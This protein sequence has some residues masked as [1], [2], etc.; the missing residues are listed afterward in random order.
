[1]RYDIFTGKTSLVKFKSFVL[2]MSFVGNTINFLQ[3]KWSLRYVWVLVLNKVCTTIFH[4]FLFCIRFV[5]FIT[6]ALLPLTKGVRLAKSN[7]TPLCNDMRYPFPPP[8]HGAFIPSVS[9]MNAM[10]QLSSIL[11]NTPQFFFQIVKHVWL[12][13]FNLPLS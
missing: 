6:K 12:A 7:F 9:A 1:M 11:M 3:L 5:L 8:L 4:R 10:N 2:D 13:L